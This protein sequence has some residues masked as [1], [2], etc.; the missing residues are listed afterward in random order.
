MS[1]RSN[2]KSSSGEDNPSH[3]MH[4]KS[5]PITISTKYKEDPNR[6]MMAA[7]WFGTEDVRVNSIPAPDITDAGDAI[8][9]ITTATICGS[10]L[11]MYFNQL[12]APRGVGMQKGDV[13]GHESMGIVDRVGPNVKNI[14]VGQR[15]V[16]SAPIACGQ[17][18]YCRDEKYSLCDTT[19]PSTGME[20][21]YGYRTAGIFGYSHL[22]GGIAGGQA[23][24]TRVPFADINLLPIPDNI[25]DEQALLLSDV[26]C[27]GYHGTELAEVTQ[28]SKVVVWGCGPV[29]LAAAYLAK[30]RGAATVISIDNDPTRLEKAR[31]FGA[32]TINFDEVKSVSDEITQRIPGGPSNCIDCVGYR[33]P[34]SMLSWVQMKLKIETDAVDIVKEMILTARKGAKLALIGDYFNYTNGFPIGAFMEKG[35]SMAGGQLW[36][37]KYWHHLLSLIQSGDMDFTFLFSHRYR[38]SD[39]PTAYK[40]FGHHQ[41]NCTKV[42]IKTDYGVQL[43]E[44][45][46]A[47]AATNKSGMSTSMMNQWGKLNNTVRPPTHATNIH[48]RHPNAKGKDQLLTHI[49]TSG[50]PASTVAQGT[51]NSSMGTS[52]AGS[53]LGAQSSQIGVGAVHQGRIQTH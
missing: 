7:Q 28:G 52:V 2:D 41:D 8:V 23:E 16:I 37:Q 20:T 14:R 30:L 47:T 38:L 18:E 11:H 5:R 49:G 39:I 4:T 26:I 53:G 40:T 50:A 32:D 6:T 43:E 10:D 45:R 15:V 12:P 48:L 21:L 19:N 9:R 1:S 36:C 3:I 17:C 34:K 33:F 22:T 27:T 31:S 35:Q 29:G 25:T 42:I 46:G 51:T 24:Y 44:Q 13:M